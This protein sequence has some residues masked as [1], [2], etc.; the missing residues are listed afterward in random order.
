MPRNPASYSQELE[1]KLKSLKPGDHLCCIYGT[2]DEHRALLTPFLAR[3]LNLGEKVVYIVDVRPA[4]EVLAYLREAGME[5]D[6]YLETGQLKLLAA[7]DTYMR[8]GVFDPDVM[9]SLLREETEL[10]LAEGYS[11][12][13]VTGEMTWALRGL[14]GS[15]RLIEYEARL[16]EFFPRHRCLAICQYDM[17]RFVPALLL[18]V[19]TTHPIAVIGT[20]LFDNF[21]YIPPEELLHDDRDAACL[22]NWLRGLEV[23][24]QAEESLRESE[25]RLRLAGEAAGFSTYNYDFNKR[26]V[27]WPAELKALYGLKPDEALVMDKD[28][29][30][31]AIHPEDREAFLAAITAASD[32]RGDGLLE[33]E[34]RILRADGA[35]RWQSARGRT[36]FTG[37][38][39]ARR[40]RHTSGVVA[41]IT[42][43]KRAEAEAMRAR[44]DWERTF[45]AVPDMIMILGQSHQIVR[46]NRAMAERLG[47]AAGE[48]VGRRCYEVLHG[49]DAPPEACPHTQ[50]LADGREH[51][52]EVDEKRLNRV[53]FVSVAP[54]LDPDGR[55]AGAVH[56]ARDITEQKSA[57]E[58]L[59]RAREVLED[60]FA[61]AVAGSLDGLWEWDLATGNV[62][63]SDRFLELLGYGRDEAPATL[64][65]VNGILH[66]EDAGA[67]W[68]AA[69]HHLIDRRPYDAEFR[70]RTKGGEYR[71]FLARGRAQWDAEGHPVRIAGSL[72]DITE[73]KKLEE[74]LRESENRLAYALEASVEGVWDWNIKTGKVYYSPRWIESLGYSREEVPSEVG[75]WE[76]IVHPDDMP[77]V[78]EAL[79]AHFEGRTPVYHVEDRL[80]MK[81]GEY[82]WN[83]D[84]GKVVER[85]AEGQPLRMVGTDTDITDRKRA[86]EELRRLRDDLAHIGRAT[87]M[88]ELAAA[89][90]HEVNQ[91]LAAI[92]AN[93]RAA[94]HFLGGDSPDVNEAQEALNDIIDDDRR[95]GEVIRRLRSM[96][97][98]EPAERKALDV[99]EM[100]DEVI[101]LVRNELIIRGLELTFNPAG[102]L[103]RVVG[104]RVQIQQVVLNLVRNALEAMADT[105]RPL[106]RVVIRTQRDGPDTTVSVSDAGPHISEAVLAALFEP[107]HTTKPDGLG[108]GLAISRSIIQAH[109]GRIWAERNPDRGLT[110]HF[111]LP[112]PQP[113]ADP[114][115]LW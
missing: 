46:A 110:V 53:L 33:L 9:I 108:M 2:D 14:P 21:Y 22:R 49:T 94:Q 30:P 66:P 61:L 64:D 44:D 12:L 95:A 88:G 114:C 45:E 58:D 25:L 15:E 1:E 3:G 39:D 5:I 35:V 101:L 32:P 60:R 91:P 75:F 71:W 8:V 43:R 115:Q 50:L 55:L 89:I 69:D 87:A 13:R 54:L 74:T 52:A 72:K 106:R 59:R 107:F 81:S 105:P 113:S 31:A 47:C 29:V 78:Q 36:F 63:Y 70:L 62:F 67:M 102:D 79:R 82:R 48:L 73:R 90:A 76:N 26:E 37:S 92:L 86:E 97:R 40:P 83:L 28:M 93:A 34:Y 24:K 56:V 84:R 99:N 38:G 68:S 57:A 16:N 51:Q 20:R 111:T 103:P 41:D 85:D 65:F 112:C 11:A 23:R 109:G 10:A 80:R 42:D 27:Q 77:R 4:E 96:L 98:R 18:D 19:L 17:R 6:G 104:D 100:I 7:A